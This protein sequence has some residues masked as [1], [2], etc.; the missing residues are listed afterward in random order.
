MVQA[1]RKPIPPEIEASILRKSARRCALC[2]RLK[3]DLAEKHGQIAHL[4]KRRTNPVEDNLAFLCMEHHSLYDSTTRQHKNYTIQEV[5]SARGELYEAITRGDHVIQPTPPTQVT[6]KR[7]AE[8]DRQTLASLTETLGGSVQFLRHVNFAAG[9]FSPRLTDGLDIYIG[10]SGDP[11]LEF[12]DP[13]LETLRKK[14]LEKLRVIQYSIAYRT[15]P[16]PGSIPQL[17]IPPEWKRNQPERYKETLDELHV[18]AD[19][20]CSAHDELVRA[21]RSRPAQ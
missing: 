17:S 11:H 15:F 13:E 16:T 12:I 20:A 14:L 18:A 1:P 4:D 8:E 9:P 6:V 21:A 5:K 19:N 3:K 2:F 7:G 10:R